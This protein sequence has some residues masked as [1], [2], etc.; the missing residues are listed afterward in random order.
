M[1]GVI[2]E[3]MVG[4]NPSDIESM[5]VLKDA[6]ATA[7]YGARAS[8]GVV[9][10]TTKKGKA[11]ESRIN[12]RYSLGV[13]QLREKYDVLSARDY[14]FYGRL[15]VAA[16][17]EKH[18]ERLTWLDASHGQGIGNDLTNN[19]AFTPQYLTPENE[20]KLN[21]GW[22][23]MPDPL[24]PS[25]TII[26]DETDWQDVLFSTGVTH[27]HYLSFSGGTEKATI[28]LGVGYTDVEGVAIQ[29]N[30]RR[31][32]ANLNG[33]LQV[34]EHIY[35]FGGL[36][37]S[38][39]TSHAV[40]SEN[41]LF[42][43]AIAL[44]PTAK[45]RYEDGT[46][47]PGNNKS[48][49]N[50]EYHL[51]RLNNKNKLSLF[52]VTGGANWELLPG[53]NFEATTSLFYKVGD[54]TSF[55]QSYYNTPT[56]FI[57]SRD[58]S[59]LSATWDQQQIDAT[60]G[61]EK[62][63]DNAHHFQAKIG[64]SYFHREND[65]LSAQ[66]RG[67]ATDLIPTINA[68][69]EPVSV[70]SFA[71][72]QVIL[73][74]F[75][76]VIYDYQQKYLFTLNARYDGASNLGNENKW[77]VFPGVSAGWNLHN[78]AFWNNPAR[79]SRLKLRASYGVNGNL[80]NL[81]DF[82]A[83][84]RYAVG[85]RYQGIA[86]VEY[87]EL[88]NQELQWEQSKTFDIGFDVGFLNNRIY[89]LFDYY[90]RITDNLITTL[91]L[92][93]LT[94]FTSILTNLGSLQ[95]QGI[96]IE[97]GATLLNANNF[98]W[99]V[100]F[101]AAR[102]ENEI[103]KLPEN[104]NENNRIGGYNVYDPAVGDYVWKGGLQE[105]GQV[106]DLFGYQYL[107]VYATDAEAA[108]GPVDQLVA[109]ADKTKFGGDVAWLDLDNNGE[110]DLRDRV[111]MGNIYPTWTGGFSTTAAYKGLGL[112][113]RFDY[114]TGH[115]IYN[116]VRANMNGQ[117][118]GDV[119]A[120]TDVLRSWIAQGDETDIPRYYWADQAAQANYWRGDPRSLSN[121]AGSSMNYERGD[122]LALREI[123]LSYTA[124]A[125]WLEAIGIESLRFN[126][127]GSNL[128]YFTNYQG[129]SPEEGGMD[130]GRYPVP[131]GLLFGVNASF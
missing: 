65:V 11:G 85:N 81:S 82:Q 1:D 75:G 13:S 108:E 121:G 30:Y 63:I 122:Y 40:Y 62:S 42:E 6:A 59:G 107:S 8:N 106:G 45:Y 51:S 130:R 31:F 38:R 43:R 53:L 128:K 124:P 36:N 71:S 15:S 86:A 16:I 78:E 37:L 17:G 2:R 103:L 46:L 105:G 74:Y 92:P 41:N 35:V 129:L 70:F 58:A 94:G 26:F 33:K 20:Y 80:G 7:I 118:V 79:M 68:S 44:P 89:T 88:A 25:K 110:I 18:P 29:T 102:N 100:S 123:T 5:Q 104:E 32:T 120:T 115:T 47:A 125:A 67:A 39:A 48:L 119:N 28:N 76:R 9:I 72:K 55:Q 126:V 50:P 23:S 12:Y 77:G 93:Q 91:A 49:G 131:R 14:I 111:K 96:E 116:Y 22:Q 66:G 19:T 101:N 84:G 109:G 61:Y 24:D 56:Q 34:K 97:V 99:D 114:T 98:T 90:R 95:N 112:Y 57:D 64:I 27:D 60:L 69:A 73:G 52:T 87:A 10:I 3:D 4:I 113:A 117:F 54:T 83:Q 127:T 21:E